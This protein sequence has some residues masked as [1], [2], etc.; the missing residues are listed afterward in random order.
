MLDE[1]N[2]EKLKEIDFCEQ[3]SHILEI[4]GRR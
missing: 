3:Q 2:P 4:I 1:L